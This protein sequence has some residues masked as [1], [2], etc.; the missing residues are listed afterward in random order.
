MVKPT[1]LLSQ[2]QIKG[3]ITM[4]DV[5]EAVEKTFKGMGDGTVINPTKV[6]LDLGETAEF[7]PYNGFMNAMPA[8]IGWLDSAGIK[9]A[10]G[11]LG[12][13]RKIGL[14][15][16]TS[17][18]LLID[19]K[20]GNFRAV[21]DG[22]YITN[23]RT[24]GQTAVALK[25]L[26]KKPEIKISLYGAG[27]QGRTHTMAISE[28]FRISEVRVYDINPDT[29]RSYAEQMKGFVSGGIV[30]AK[31]PEE[32]SGGDVAICVTQSKEK[33]FRYEWFKPGTI[34]VPIGSYQ[35][36]DDEC[37]LNADYIIVDHVGQTLHRGALAGLSE[38]GKI[39]E[40][41]LHGTIGEVLAGKKPLPAPDKRTLTILI[42]T[43]AL[44]VTVATIAYNRAVEKGIGG[45]YEFV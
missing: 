21:L 16:I 10:G 19:P 11:F 36:C 39:T 26:W 7:P 3:L 30:L 20:I 2:E 31:T 12:E 18:I 25:H 42:G 38:R 33:F 32:A 14:P 15:Y 4:K 34:L 1:L 35:E 37:I 6:L 17:L 40:S 41:S 24:G 44:D 9:W 8:Y 13:R 23:L 45:T 28:F 27:M 22:E 43:G 5:V 29:Q